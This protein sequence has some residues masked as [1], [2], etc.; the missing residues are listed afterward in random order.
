[1]TH[2]TVNNK[3]VKSAII[4]LIGG[5]LTKIV[6]FILKIIITRKIGT[7]GIGLYSMIGPT[8]SLLSVIAV[9]SYPAAISTLVSNN[10]YSSRKLITSILP[11]SLLLNIIIIILVVLFAPYLSTNLLKNKDLYLPIICVAITIPF[12]S[13]SSIVKGYFWGNQNMFPYMLSNFIEQLTR[14]SLILLFIDK[15][16]KIS[17]IYSIC[18]IILVNIVGEIISII[19]MILFIDNKKLSI[20]DFKVNFKDIKTILSICIP[21]TISKLIGSFSYF[22]E[23]II[24]TNVLL[25]MN[26]T[27]NYIT[28]EY[29]IINAYSLSLLL[30]PQFFTQN[31]STALIPELSKH[32]GRNNYQM[33]I[34]R[35]KQIV[36]VSFTIGIISTLIIVIFPKF[37][38]NILYHTNEG[39]DYIRLL[40]PFTI[41]YYIEYPLINALQ[42]IEAS[43]EI[44]KITIIT[45]IIRIITITLFSLLKIG[46][47]SL[48]ISIVINILLSTY[49]YYNKLKKKLLL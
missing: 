39:V 10:N 11:F 19:I 35:I 45:S 29:G 30:M 37:F 16:Y 1:M 9:F 2:L 49:L 6:G 15:I 47:Y 38:L 40:A 22:L 3:F 8:M 24:L 27:K 46:M 21:N 7:E 14:L 33:C 23:P 4:L 13:F 34:K 28:Y 32:Y 5:S 31:M 20:R 36:A 44:L 43:N 25:F 12:I 41:I 26:Y 42:T 48:V 18:F 17:L